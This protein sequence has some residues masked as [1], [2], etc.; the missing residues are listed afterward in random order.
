[1]GTDLGMVEERRQVV[2]NTR[3]GAAAESLRAAAEH[4]AEV[5]HMASDWGHDHAVQLPGHMQRAGVGSPGLL[6]VLE[7]TQVAGYTSH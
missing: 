3:F 4:R 1:M 2:T 5:E 6:L 7:S